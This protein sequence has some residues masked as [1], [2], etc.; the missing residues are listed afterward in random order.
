VTRPITD[1]ERQYVHACT[2]SDEPEMRRLQNLLDRDGEQRNARLRAPEALAQ[3]AVW[4]AEQG[5]A[6][7]PLHHP[8]GG[9]CSCRDLECRSQGKH[10][11]T[12]T[13]FKDASTDPDVVRQWWQRWPSANIGAPTGL[14][15]DV[16]DID[17]PDGIRSILGLNPDPA[18]GEGLE[19]PALPP[20]IGRSIT[21]RGGGHHLFTPATGRGNRTR[22]YPGVDYRGA[23]GYVVLPPSRGVNGRLYA[24]MRPIEL[25][26]LT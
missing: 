3:A 10:P 15:F 1:L 22:L 8:E 25:D 9:T 20:I 21:P 12:P 4:Y 5:I 26:T 13:G 14:R 16:I 17:G 18:D 7:F 2:V 19:S 11:R 23:G 24:W 6:V